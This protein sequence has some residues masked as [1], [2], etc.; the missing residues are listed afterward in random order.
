[1]IKTL[2]IVGFLATII[3]SVWLMVQVVRII[4]NAF[5][6]LASIADS[7]SNYRG[8]EGD[9]LTIATGK[10]IVNSGESF[11]I[12]WTDLERDGTYN[13]GYSCTEGIAVDVRV[14][15][16]RIEEV[17]CGELYEIPNGQFSLDVIVTS[18]KARFT[19]IPFSILFMD[20]EEEDVTF[21]ENSKVTV[22]N[23]TIPQSAERIAEEESDDEEDEEIA[24]DTEDEDEE[25]DEEV[26]TTPARPAPT[27][28]PKPKPTNTVISYIPTSQANGFTDLSAR[29]IGIGELDGNDFTPRAT[30]E[31][32]ENGALK[33]E[34]KNI[35]TKT[36]E[37]W[38]FEV[39]LPSGFVYESDEQSPL[40]PNERVEFTLGFFPTEDDGNALIEMRLETDNDT[41]SRNDSFTWSVRITD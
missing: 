14:S 39:M 41:N 30:L 9:E 8:E 40:K 13:F 28:A 23:A 38:A 22:V 27:P 24:T 6:S 10:S 35:G 7:I 37:E 15:G 33:F 25:E 21:E 2:A 20:T 26:A 12:A 29:F 17:P 36:S 16:D 3:L 19:D 31:A 34:V 11:Q 32:D 5:S 4:P 18:E 1:M